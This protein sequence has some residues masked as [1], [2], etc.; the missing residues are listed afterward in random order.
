MERLGN[1][2]ARSVLES[3]YFKKLFVKTHRCYSILIKY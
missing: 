3:N 2:L 1:S